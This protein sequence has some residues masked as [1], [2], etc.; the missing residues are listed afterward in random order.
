MAP[1]NLTSIEE[2][3]EFAIDSITRGDTHNGKAVLSWV[4]R[5]SPSHPAAWIWMACCVDD[6]GQKRDCY[7]RI[8]S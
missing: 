5:Q 7:R 4:L 1:N 8:S 3:M 6:E 2:A